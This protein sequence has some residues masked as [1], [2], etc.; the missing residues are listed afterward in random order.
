MLLK[1]D[2]SFHSFGNLAEERFSRYT[3]EDRKQSFFFDFKSMV[4][5]S[6]QKHVLLIFHF[7]IH[8]IF[9]SDNMQMLNIEM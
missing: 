4:S 8:F 9:S 1:P 6:M 5:S 3:E 2:K 7:Y